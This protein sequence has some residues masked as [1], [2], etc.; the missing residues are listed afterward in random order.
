KQQAP[1]TTINGS[2]RG[3]SLL[4]IDGYFRTES[5]L[6]FEWHSRGLIGCCVRLM[7]STDPK[8]CRTS[9]SRRSRTGNIRADQKHERSNTSDGFRVGLLRRSFSRRLRRH[10]LASLKLSGSITGYGSKESRFHLFE[11]D[12]R[13]IIGSISTATS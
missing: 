2:T 8:N 6:I 12:R 5:R 10:L 3:L 11:K 9:L 4:G 1:R 7:K 13:E